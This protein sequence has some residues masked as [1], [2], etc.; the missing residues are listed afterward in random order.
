VGGPVVVTD[1]DDEHRFVL[2][3]ISGPPEPV[4]VLEVRGVLDR[5]VAPQFF[6]RLDR[7][8]AVSRG[9][10][11]K[12]CFGVRIVARVV[13]V[14]LRRADLISNAVLADLAVRADRFA[15]RLRLVVPGGGGLGDQLR[16]LGLGDRFDTFDDVAD[17]VLAVRQ[18]GA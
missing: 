12:K 9:R 7:A 3:A 2:Y 5:E 13:V 6:R 1:S 18:D 11:D 15:C 16:L 17:A 4:L 10:H 8:D 14:D